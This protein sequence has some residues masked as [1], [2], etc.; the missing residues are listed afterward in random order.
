[1]RGRALVIWITSAVSYVPKDISVLV[2]FWIR[3]YNARLK[4]PRDLTLH[5]TAETASPHIAHSRS[6]TPN[7]IIFPLQGDAFF[8]TRTHFF[9]RSFFG[10]RT[11]FLGNGYSSCSGSILCGSRVTHTNARTSR[12]N[13]ERIKC[14]PRRK[15]KNIV[16]THPDFIHSPH[17]PHIHY[18]AFHL[19]LLP[20]AAAWMVAFPSGC[21]LCTSSARRFSSWNPW[22]F[23]SSSRST[24]RSLGGRRS[25]FSWTTWTRSAH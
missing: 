7:F 21:R 3:I 10:R 2:M 15:R 23:C 9:R 17:E 4:T 6:C 5:S 12:N 24:G 22:P 14:S 25:A 1:M 19:I 16:H 8:S 11:I 13:R 18:V 20:L